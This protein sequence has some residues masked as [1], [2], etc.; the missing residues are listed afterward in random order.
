MTTRQEQHYL[1]PKLMRRF[2][3]FLLLVIVAARSLLPDGYF[4]H[5]N[6]LLVNASL[7]DGICDLD[8]PASIGSKCNFGE[9]PN[10]IVSNSTTTTTSSPSTNN[11]S[12]NGMHCICPESYTGIQ[13]EFTYESCNDKNQHVCYNGGK[14][15][16]GGVDQ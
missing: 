6:I 1:H 15:Q 9:S 4:Q 11:K 13:C 10:M 14:C 7:S 16:S 8:C 2:Q 3:N 12:I 5:W